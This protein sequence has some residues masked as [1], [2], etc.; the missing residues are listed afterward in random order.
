MKAQV[1]QRLDIPVICYSYFFE[2]LSMFIMF[3]YGTRNFKNWLLEGKI[4]LQ[5][6]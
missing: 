1:S 4:E 5:N 2:S 6:V 3:L